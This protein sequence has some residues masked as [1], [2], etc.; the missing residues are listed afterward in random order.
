MGPQ[1]TGHVFISYAREDQTY[2]RNL[3]DSLRKRGFEPWM[4]DRLRS[5][6]R[7]WQ[8]IDEA[9]Q[10]CAAFIVVMT[11]D[12]N[13]SEW[14]ER[15]V[16][17]AL[18]EQKPILPLLLR[19]RRFSVLVNT[20]YDDVTNGRMP[21]DEFYERLEQ[22]APS[23]K[24]AKSQPPTT[25]PQPKPPSKIV[26]SRAEKEHLEILKQ[27]VEAWN[28]WRKANPLARPKLL[29]A[30]LSGADLSGADLSGA[31]LFGANLRGA[32]LSRANLFG[33]D[34]RWADLSRAYLL[35]ANLSRAKYNDFTV[36]PTFFPPPSGAIKVE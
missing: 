22:V 29:S 6:D 2:V 35:G 13:K 24:E 33:A 1:A 30:D 9:I 23:K 34:L 3:A 7:W 36:W 8:T 28:Q 11:P 18:D 15:E 31:N 17:L 10:E 14:V 20:Q 26:P 32:D 21:P 19:G 4:D 5:G 16:M 27:G 12:S 25:Q